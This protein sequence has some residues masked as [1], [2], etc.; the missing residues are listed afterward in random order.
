MQLYKTYIQKYFQTFRDLIEIL[1]LQH[2]FI[3]AVQIDESMNESA[4][5]P[6]GPVGKERALTKVKDS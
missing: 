4:K 3:P 6:R 5:V 1:S 2:Q